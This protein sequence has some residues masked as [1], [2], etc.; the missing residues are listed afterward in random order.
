MNKINAIGLD[1]DKAKHLAEKLNELL[2]N[3]SIFYQNTRGYH[4]NIKGEKF[5]ELHL[6]FEELYNDLLLKVDEV[7]ERILTLGHTPKHNYADYRTTSKIKESVFVSDGIKAVEDILASF[8]TIIILQRE[9]LVIASDAGDEGTN[10]LMSDY[11]RLQE[12]SVWMYSS[13]LKK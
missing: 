10:A 8:Q 7:A 3:Y 5:F 11:I 2:A 4:W 9:L 6:K 13:F 12:K 1:N